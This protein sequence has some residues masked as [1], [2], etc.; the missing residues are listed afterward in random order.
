MNA[1]QEYLEARVMTAPKQSLHLLVVDGALR[2]ARRAEEALES[3]DRESAHRA[4]NDSSAFVGELINGLDHKAAPEI[5]ANLASLFTFVY[6]RLV[7]ADVYGSVEKIRDAIKILGIHREGWVEV[8]EKCSAEQKPD[9][10]A[11]AAPVTSFCSETESPAPRRTH[12]L[13]EYEH[14]EPR[15]WCG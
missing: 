13:S 2:H 8:L 12:M 11:Q 1:A 4:I 9:T 6:R 7:E 3:G 15:S 14:Y 5:V 10:A